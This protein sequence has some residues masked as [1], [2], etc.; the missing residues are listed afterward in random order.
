M[1]FPFGEWNDVLPFNAAACELHRKYII[2]SRRP[3]LNGMTPFPKGESPKGYC[4][5]Y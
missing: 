4:F 3:V 1:R 5:L 2:V